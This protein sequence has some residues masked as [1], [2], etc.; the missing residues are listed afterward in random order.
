MIKQFN[1]Y[2]IYGYL[3]PGMLLLG[4]LWLPIGMVTGLPPSKDIS[5]AV[6]VAALAYI[7]GHLVRAVSSSVVPSTVS[8]SHSQQRVMS[9]YLLDNSNTDSKWAPN[10][11]LRLQGQVQALFNISLQVE[12]D[13]DGVNAIS[14]D[15]NT[16]FFQARA[17]LIAKDAAA[18]A[19]QFEGMYSMMRGLG[20]CFYVGAAYFAG[21][22]ILLYEKHA[23]VTLCMTAVTVLGVCGT[24]WFA[25]RPNLKEHWKKIAAAIF[26]LI[27]FCGIGF[28]VGIGSARHFHHLPNPNVRSLLAAG[29]V[30]M[31]IAAMKCFSAYREFARIFAE[32]VWRDF[33][34]CI[35]YGAKTGGKA[36]SGDGD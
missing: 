18:Y 33:S 11:K 4:I 3:L 12:N 7:V 30:I 35:A 19:E 32:T 15:R 10:F 14:K 29:V 22:C 20:C 21:W 26:W 25:L 23:C 34:A 2:D 27:S 28:W 1:F 6:Y 5:E 31:V 8:D 13:G 24:L 9:D 16:A 36:G 17:Y